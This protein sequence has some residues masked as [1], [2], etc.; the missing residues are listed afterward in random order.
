MCNTLSG[1]LLGNIFFDFA[2]TMQ[3]NAAYL[4]QLDEAIGDGDHG[5]NMALGFQKIQE[6]FQTM[7]ASTPDLL[8]RTAGMT[9]VT[10]V[11]GASGP[12]YGAA[13]IAA[14]M[15]ARTNSDLNLV[16]LARMVQA[17]EEALVRRGRCRLGDKTIFDVLHPASQAL[18]DS[19]EK[20]LDLLTGL[21]AAVVAAKR[22]MES[23][24]PLVARRGLAMQYGSASVGHQDPGATSCYLLFESLYKTVRQYCSK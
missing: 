21:E 20:N 12:L 8:L 24:V 5:W 15:E 22:G 13:F 9:L 11:S 14:G 16:N 17:A 4:T 10:T 1:E 18:A 7:A 3:T 6:Q 19:A 2:A 23:T